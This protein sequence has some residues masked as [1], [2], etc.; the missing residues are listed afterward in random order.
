MDEGTAWRNFAATGS[1]ADYLIYR[2]AKAC[3]PQEFFDKH[4]EVPDEVQNR[5][6]D[7]DGTDNKRE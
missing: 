7:T 6:S 3:A 4:T 1:V 2:E 5:R